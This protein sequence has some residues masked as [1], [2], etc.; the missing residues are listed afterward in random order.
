MAKI[1]SIKAREILDSRGYPTVEAVVT[2]T[3]AY[4]AYASVPSG[5]S[6]GKREA[7][8]LRDNDPKRYKGKGV[9]KACHHIEAIIA[10]HLLNADPLDQESIDRK[11][12]EL[13]AT[14]NKNH[15]GANAILAVSL[16]IKKVA[17]LLQHK[18]LFMTFSNDKHWILPVPMMNIINGGCHASNDLDFQ[19]FMIMPIGTN[20]FNEAIRMGAEVFHVLKLLL[21]QNQYHTTVGDEGGFAPQLKSEESALDFLMLAIEQA[22]FTPGKDIVLALDLASSEF[23][24]EGYYTV[25]GKRLSPERLV[26]L[27]SYLV[28]TYPIISIEDGMAENDWQGWKLLTDRLGQQCQLVGDDLFVTNQAIL[29]EGISKGIANAILLKLNQIGTVTETL[30]AYN[31]AKK[32]QYNTIASHRSGET[33]ETFIADFAVGANIGQIKTGSLSRSERNCKYNQLMRIENEYQGQ[34]S[35][36]P[37]TI[38]SKY[39]SR[40]R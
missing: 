21:K 1:H 40:L 5:A 12:V 15:L 22:G 35:Y 25:D 10:P 14:P 17:A 9:K 29:N 32:H 3:N 7:L 6:T 26:E 20:S 30:S 27:L 37:A 16:A 18:P 39:I 11:L 23:F 2:L 4:Q 28:K 33:E 8:E 31:L 34:V 36:T 19:E 38:L 13:D 24:K